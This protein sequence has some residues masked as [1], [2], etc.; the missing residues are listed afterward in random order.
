MPGLLLQKGLRQ[1]ILN[2]TAKYMT[3]NNND[4]KDLYWVTYKAKTNH[5][6]HKR[7]TKQLDFTRKNTKDENT[8][9]I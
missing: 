2:K 9:S 8:K 7:I 1:T 3:K 4:K 5:Q 6:S